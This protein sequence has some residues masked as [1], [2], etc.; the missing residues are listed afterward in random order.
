MLA[1]PLLAQLFAI[2]G[3]QGTSCFPELPPSLLRGARPFRIRSRHIQCAAFP[4]AL[5]G[6]V[7][8]GTMTA[9]RIAVTGTGRVSA[10]AGSFREAALDHAV[11]GAEEF[12]KKSLPT[13][14][15]MLGIWLTL[16]KQKTPFAH[17]TG[18]GEPRK[19]KLRTPIFAPESS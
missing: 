6:D 17:S 3:G 13:H 7:E 18:T 5:V 2:Q 1:R 9:G 15:C 14:N 12:A 19:S 11:G 10:A 8:M 16:V 4:L